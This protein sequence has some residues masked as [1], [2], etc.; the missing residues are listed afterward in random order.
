MDLGIVGLQDA[1]VVGRGGFAVVYRAFQPAFRRLVAV[2]IL[3]TGDLDDV[4]RRRFEREC[5]AMGVLSG[6][7]GIVTVHDAGFTADNRP[8]IVMAFVAGGTL[9]DRVRTHG[10]VPWSA[11]APIG[12]RLAGALET[13]HRAG[14]IH[15]DVKPGNVLMSGY[16][17]LLSDF[18]IAS[19]S[20]ATETKSGMITA[21]FEHAAPEVLDGNRPSV[22]SDIYSL[23]ST[24]FAALAGAAAFSRTTDESILPLIVRV[25]RDPVPDLRDHG[26]PQPFQDILNKAMAKA[27]ADRYASAF[28]LGEALREVQRSLGAAPTELVIDEPTAAKPTVTIEGRSGELPPPRAPA[29]DA[30][31]S[32]VRRS[33]R[34]VLLAAGAVALL[35]AGGGVWYAAASGEDAASTADTAVASATKPTGTPTST[36]ATSTGTSPASTSAASGTPATSTGTSP[37]STSAPASTVPPVSNAP[38]TVATLPP[39]RRVTRIDSIGL[40][41]VPVQLVD[42]R[43][44]TALTALTS[45]PGTDQLYAVSDAVGGAL[46]ATQFDLTVDLADDRLD[47]GDVKFGP[48]TPLRNASGGPYGPELDLEAMTHTLGGQIVIGSLGADVGLGPSDLF[49]DELSPGGRFNREWSLPDW[50]LP[51][52]DGTTGLRPDAGLSS[53]TRL[54]NDQVLAGFSYT[55]H[56][57]EKSPEYGDDKHVRILAYDTES[58]EPVAEYL[59]P[60]DATNVAYESPA[61]V[62]TPSALLDLV[63]LEGTRTVIAM[64]RSMLDEPHGVKLYEVI[65]DPAK[66]AVP[67]PE[68]PR[69]T[70]TKKFLANVDLVVDP[71]LRGN[72]RSIAEGPRLTGGRRSLILVRDNNNT[73]DRSTWFRAYAIQT[74]PAP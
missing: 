26:V 55:L 63:V 13:A 39:A 2:K 38:A 14:I 12:V 73:L 21:S 1:E 18:G 29:G 20:G 61:G 36:P 23:G 66:A 11:V 6:H 70:L 7:P 52:P 28:E 33:R 74:A 72:W 57:D 10:A 15:R 49:I 8:Y 16:G 45:D 65:L 44:L 47:D 67:S 58:A 35:A 43:P 25:Q 32:P 41:E 19:V 60:L 46:E 9:A 54:G 5:Q 48:A 62:L 34:T 37:A 24:M 17:A 3:N 22:A 42:G 69:A 51:D 56:Q 59:Y 4:T 31:A 27:P 53:L 64:E 71:E 40:A 30:A 68:G 50:Y